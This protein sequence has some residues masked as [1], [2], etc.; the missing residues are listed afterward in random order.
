[1]FWVILGRTNC[2][3]RPGNGFFC[4]PPTVSRG[5]TQKETT[6]HCR[7]RICFE[8]KGGNLSG[9]APR[10]RIARKIANSWFGGGH[11]SAPCVVKGVN[12]SDTSQRIASVRR[13]LLRKDR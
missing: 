7:C 10:D 11:R 5:P 1:M 9:R 2:P 8:S 12:I 6:S 4:S 13:C 3:G